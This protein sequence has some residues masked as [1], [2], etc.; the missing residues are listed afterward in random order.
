MDTDA[1][2]TLQEPALRAIYFMTRTEVKLDKKQALV[3]NRSLVALRN[4]Y[5]SQQ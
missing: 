5:E 1:G 2:T 3:H 4:A